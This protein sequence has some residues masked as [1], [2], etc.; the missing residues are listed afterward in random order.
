VLTRDGSLMRSILQ[1]R[2][3]HGSPSATKTPKTNTCATYSSCSTLGARRRVRPVCNPECR[4]AA[5]GPDAP[6]LGPG[7]RLT[8]AC[9]TC[10]RRCSRHR[11]ASRR[12]KRPM[13]RTTRA[14]TPTNGVST[15]LLMHPI[16]GSLIH[17]IADPSTMATQRR[18]RG[19]R[20]CC[21]AFDRDARTRPSIGI[22]TTSAHGRIAPYLSFAATGREGYLHDAGKSRLVGILGAGAG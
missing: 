10:R 17:R 3:R 22:C 20:A 5:L 11:T 1:R 13:Q 18:G 12:R 15:A 19:G 14:A 6:E 8:E 7:L 9:S 21:Y 2:R 4:D 16:N